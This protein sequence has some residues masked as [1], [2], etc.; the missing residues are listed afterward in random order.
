MYATNTI[1]HFITIEDYRFDSK[2]KKRELFDYSRIIFKATSDKIVSIVL[3]SITLLR[4][5]TPN[6][7]NVVI[8]VRIL[9]SNPPANK[10]KTPDSDGAQ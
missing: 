5:S 4:L 9:L 2:H 1:L 8:S 7:N 10:E 3:P 6:P